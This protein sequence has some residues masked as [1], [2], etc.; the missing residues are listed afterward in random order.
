MRLALERAGFVKAKA[1][2]LLGMTVRQ[3]DWRVRKYGIAVERF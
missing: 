1:A 2:R 3:L